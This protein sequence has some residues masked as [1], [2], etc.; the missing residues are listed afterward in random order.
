[1]LAIEVFRLGHQQEQD[2]GVR[3][4]STFLGRSPHTAT[5]ED[6][7][8]FQAHLA[9]TSTGQVTINATTTALKFSFDI[10]LAR[11]ALMRKMTRVAVS[12]LCR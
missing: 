7:H 1:M 4:L 6:L 10:T 3:K 8:R 5:A 2:H 12:A 11:P 9:D